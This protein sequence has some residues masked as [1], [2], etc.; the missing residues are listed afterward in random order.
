MNDNRDK[1]VR[2]DVMD[3]LSQ[4]GFHDY[5]NNVWP[6]CY[7][8]LY[9]RIIGSFGAV[10]AVITVFYRLQGVEPE[11]SWLWVGMLTWLIPYVGSITV[12]ALIGGAV[13]VGTA[14]GMLPNDPL[15][16]C[17]PY[18]VYHPCSQE[19][20]SKQSS[21]IDLTSKHHTISV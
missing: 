17:N 13:L 10:F 8:L 7:P 4:I 20:T 14:L 11:Y 18:D 9:F 21:I 6:F 3:L 19:G 16:E 12:S 15:I 2:I 5:S 1:N